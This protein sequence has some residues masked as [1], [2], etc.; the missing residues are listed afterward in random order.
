MNLTK[1][2]KQILGISLA[3]V[4]LVGVG[5][6]VY[7]ATRPNDDSASNATQISADAGVGAPNFNDYATYTL[8]LKDGE[9]LITEAGIY[10]ISG[11]TS[12]YIHVNLEDDKNVKLILNNVAITSSGTPAIFIE[13]AKNAVIELTGENSITTSVGSDHPG[14]IFSKD[15]LLIQGDG[16]LNL[17]SNEDGIVGK[18]DFEI[19]GGTINVSAGDDGIRGNDSV[20][21]S[22]GKVVILKSKEG[23]E[24]EVISITGGN[25]SVTATDDG[26]NATDKNGEGNALTLNI[27]G[28]E[29][30][31]NAGGDGLDSNGSIYIS[32]GNTRVD[33]PLNDGNGPLDYE[34][35]MEITGGTLIAVGS[36]GMAMN[37]TN[38]TQA[39]VLVGLDSSTTGTLS[40]GNLSYAPKKAYASVYITSPELKVGETYE[41]KAGSSTTS[42]TISDNITNLNIR[43]MSTMPDGRGGPTQQ[44]SQQGRGQMPPH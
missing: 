29:T 23:I 19:A 4:A 42:V 21:I 5:M 14:A 15:D 43:S 12:G 26:I 40:I 11:D 44:Q 38:S 34:E 28:G 7:H 20:K 25:I 8:A 24:S 10:S 31:V 2:Q 9:N 22:D 32:G 39:S 41:L 30:Y 13:N 36:S 16:T 3:V 18:D 37:A 6:A 1:N 27:S 35:K 17:V 33:G